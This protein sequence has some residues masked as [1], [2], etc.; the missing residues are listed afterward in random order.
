MLR[1]LVTVLRSISTPQSILC[2]M[3]ADGTAG[4][5]CPVLQW[6][7]KLPQNPVTHEENV[8]EPPQFDVEKMHENVF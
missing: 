8:F 5:L 4:T 3:H 6:L 7:V 1:A 2:E